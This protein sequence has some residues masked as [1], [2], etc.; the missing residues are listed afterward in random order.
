M[1]ELHVVSW[2]P[3]KS[4]RIHVTENKIYTQHFVHILTHFGYF[5]TH[6]TIISESGLPA[7]MF[8]SKKSRQ[9]PQD[10]GVCGERSI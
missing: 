9:K 5:S 7:W 1:D 2:F 8:L 10:L 6:S 4:F 3:L